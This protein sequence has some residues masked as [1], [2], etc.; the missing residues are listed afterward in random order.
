M[1]RIHFQEKRQGM[2]IEKSKKI[3]TCTC[4]KYLWKNTQET[5]NNECFYR[6][7]QGG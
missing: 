3:Y 7:D 4:T 5:D 2:K 1:Y 6:K